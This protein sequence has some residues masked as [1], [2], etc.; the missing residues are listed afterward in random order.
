VI[1]AKAWAPSI[2]LCVALEMFLFSLPG[3]IP[4]IDL[5][6]PG[7]SVQNSYSYRGNMK[8]KSEHKVYALLTQF[9]W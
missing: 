1:K 5:S 8:A 7:G 6:L 3:Y 9:K 4:V 2:I